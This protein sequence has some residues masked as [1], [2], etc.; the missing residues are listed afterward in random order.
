MSYRVTALANVTIRAYMPHQTPVRLGPSIVMKPGER[1]E[2]VTLRAGQVREGLGLVLG[3]HP[4][5][6]PEA[7]AW[8]INGV[9][10]VL[11]ESWSTA[12][13]PKDFFGLFRLEYLGNPQEPGGAGA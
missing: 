12:D 13:L 2:W 5:S 11:P 9:K 8:H 1:E 7:E 10:M 3:V 4:N 6:L